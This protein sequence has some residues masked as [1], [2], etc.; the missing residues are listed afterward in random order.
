M[1]NINNNQ[2]NIQQPKVANPAV[3]SS[4]TPPQA[5]G[6]NNANK[7]ST[8]NAS[9]L[10]PK[11]VLDHMTQAGKL[12]QVNIQTLPPSDFSGFKA[13]FKNVEAVLKNEFPNLSPEELTTLAS[14]VLERLMTRFEYA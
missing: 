14:Q 9:Q 1:T 6:A 4:N 7:P 5:E 3:P 2:P 10:D 11:T 8:P 12:N 13:A